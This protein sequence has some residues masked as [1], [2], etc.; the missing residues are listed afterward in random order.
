MDLTDEQWEVL[1]PLIADAAYVSALL[2]ESAEDLTKSG[3]EPG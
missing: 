2:E 3:S 1:D